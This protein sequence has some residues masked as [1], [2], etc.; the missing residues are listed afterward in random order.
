MDAA[1]QVITLPDGSTAVF[2]R[3]MDYGDVIV[4]LFL[5]IMTV[6]YIYDMWI[7]HK[8]LWNQ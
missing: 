1:T 5:L 4:A 2:I 8:A 6:L 7:R 3:A